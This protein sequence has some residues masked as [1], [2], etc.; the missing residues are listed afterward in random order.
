[1]SETPFNNDDAL[2]PSFPDPDGDPSAVA[3]SL[4]G[5]LC[6]VNGPE[7][8]QLLTCARGLA[9][10][11]HAP[12]AS[13]LVPPEIGRRLAGTYDG[14]H[15]FDVWLDDEVV[16][17]SDRALLRDWIVA[18]KKHASRCGEGCLRLRDRH[19]RLHWYRLAWLGRGPRRNRRF[20]ASLTQVDAVVRAVRAQG[21]SFGYEA[22]MCCDMPHFQAVAERLLR[23]P[24]E[25]VFVSLN[26]E[27][28]RRFN[29]QWGYA[30]GDHL[31]Q[32]L[33]RQ[34]RRLLQ[35]DDALGRMAAD[36]FVVCL[37]GGRRRAEAFVATLCSTMLPAQHAEA[38]N[39]LQARL[40]CGMRLVSPG[41]EGSVRQFCD[42]AGEA[43]RTVKGDWLRRYAWYDVALE[44]GIE[45]E[46]LVESR[47][48]GA[49]AQQEFLPVFQPRIC[50]RDGSV[51]GAEVLARWQHSAASLMPPDNFVPLFERN[52][53]IVRL[54]Y[55]IWE[56]ACRLL[57]EWLD[58]GLRPP[59]LSL[60]VSRVHFQE[61]ALVPVLLDMLAAYRLEPSQLELE[62]TESICTVDER[63]FL[64]AMQRLHDAGFRLALDD[65]G[66]GYSSVTNLCQLP[67]DV[68][69]LD[70]GLL[71]DCL[72]HARRRALLH[73]VIPLGH[74]MG[75]EV[76]A[77]GVQNLEQ[78]RFL[79]DCGCDQAQSHLFCRPLSAEDFRRRCLES[80]APFL[81]DETAGQAAAT[82]PDEQDR[83][84]PHAGCVAAPSEA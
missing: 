6:R 76:V 42:Q 28:F 46:L 1:M 4:S 22:P 16:H 29:R 49:L 5:L 18:L 82:D 77:E 83:G 81:P 10:A 19:D 61:G 38:G 65:F 68:L 80:D 26:V 39:E 62:I 3:E 43:L 13:P 63:T 11:W 15:P 51:S 23:Q 45:H 37:R 53:F 8:R 57:R 71:E 73:H 52:G 74:E 58:A 2:S 69:K 30:M 54:D 67:F 40:V 27:R 21:A 78:V 34:M 20:V 50:L 33:I 24:G 70:K 17:T 56:S 35:A 41:E 31:L 59:R 66:V 72:N 7:W 55:A 47:M 32:T 14:R 48:H 64:P 36:R 84:A 60:N 44:T 25:C 79:L 12:L 9:F 75:L